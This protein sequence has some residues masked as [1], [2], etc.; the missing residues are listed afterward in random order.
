MKTTLEPRANVRF[1]RIAAATICICLCWSLAASA[2][3]DGQLKAKTAADFKV[4]YY[5]IKAGLGNRD[6]APAADGTVW[7]ANQFSGTVGHLDPKTGKYDLFPLGRGSSPHGILMGPDGNAWAMDGGQNA[8]V[9]V[10]SRDH[11][12]TVFPLPHSVPDINLNTGVFDPA[13]VLWFTGQNGYY[14]SVDPKTGK[15]EVFD[16]PVGEGPYGITVTPKGVVWFTSFACNYIAWIDPKT[17][18]ATAVD[19]PDPHAGGSRRIWSDS[20]GRLWLATWGTGALYRYDPAD[21]SWAS[22]KLPGLGPRGYSTYVDD[23]D[24]VWVSEFMAD[25]ILRFDPQT[26][27]FVSI[28]SDRPTVQLLQMNGTHGKVWG[29]EQGSSRIVLVEPK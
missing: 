11:K 28:P 5:P 21:Q 26:E 27:S 6:V 17:H 1:I 4:T 20:K 23:E 3:M 10:D 14:G 18:R 16:A 29:G 25:A 9:R 2:Q 7:F 12:M 8:I 22:Y 24:I 19:V 13:G 15:V